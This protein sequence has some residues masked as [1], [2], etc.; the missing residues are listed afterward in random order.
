M[1]QVKD[2]Y[3][4]MIDL[5]NENDLIDLAQDM[6]D[7]HNMWGGWIVEDNQIVGY[8]DGEICDVCDGHVLAQLRKV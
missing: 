8:C 3:G 2:M 7:C 1:I 4:W 5:D 6:A